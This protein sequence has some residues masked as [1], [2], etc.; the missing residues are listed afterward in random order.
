MGDLRKEEDRW[1]TKSMTELRSPT[2]R[3]KGIIHRLITS[4]LRRRMLTSA[5]WRLWWVEVL[6]KN[7]D[8][9]DRDIDLPHP[10]RAGSLW[11]WIR[12]RLGAA[13]RQQTDGEINQGQKNLTQKTDKIPAEFLWLASHP[14][15]PTDVT[16]YQRQS[17]RIKTTCAEKKG[18]RGRRDVTWQHC[19]TM[20]ECFSRCFQA[21]KV[22]PE[23]KTGEAKHMVYFPL[24]KAFFLPR[25]SLH[26]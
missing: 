13:D 14:V 1:G 24:R 9:A 7:K 21:D 16:L 19:A 10:T 22:Q 5:L 6:F 18:Q 3:G 23:D 12:C 15:W 8:K 26:K 17:E 20:Q 25:L 11:F 4:C 2:R